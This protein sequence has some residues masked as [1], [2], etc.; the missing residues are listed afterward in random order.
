MLFDAKKNN[1]P[2]YKPKGVNQKVS[3]GAGGEAYGITI[4]GNAKSAQKNKTQFHNIFHI[5]VP[6]AEEEVRKDIG[7][8][9]GFEFKTI[10]R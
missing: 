3:V 7:I 10:Y 6:K 2:D 5:D 1:D 4:D 9:K 8:I